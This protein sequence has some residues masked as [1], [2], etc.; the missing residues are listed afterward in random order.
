MLV[1]EIMVVLNNLRT[2]Y[3]RSLPLGSS[4]MMLLSLLMSSMVV[5]MVSISL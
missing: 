2:V 1:Q 4:N 3:L 5:L